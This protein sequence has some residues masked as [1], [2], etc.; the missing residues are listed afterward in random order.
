MPFVFISVHGEF[1]LELLLRDLNQSLLCLGFLLSIFLGQQED[2]PAHD[3][4]VH[5]QRDGEAEGR[6]HGFLR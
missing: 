1:F 4:P 6:G 3:Q 5:R 2:R